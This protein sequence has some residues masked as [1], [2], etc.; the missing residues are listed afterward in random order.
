MR[1]ENKFVWWEENRTVNTLYAFS[2]EN[3]NNRQLDIHTLTLFFKEKSFYY[4]VV[5]KRI[6]VFAN[7]DMLEMTYRLKLWHA[8]FNDSKVQVDFGSIF[9]II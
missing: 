1:V 7:L 9:Y 5:P 4:K 3:I 2:P 8:D 6:A